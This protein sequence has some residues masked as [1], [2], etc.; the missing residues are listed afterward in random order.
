MSLQW[1]L[2]KLSKV[3]QSHRVAAS[4]AASVSLS[5]TGRERCWFFLI[6]TS[7]MRT[8]KV[9]F[10]HSTFYTWN[11]SQA[12]R[13]LW[14]ELLVTFYP[15]VKKAFLTYV[16]W[17]KSV[18]NSQRHQLFRY[19]CYRFRWLSFILINKDSQT[20]FDIYKKY[21]SKTISKYEKNHL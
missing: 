1:S 9:F 12:L 11:T 8:G 6:K 7:W 2:K 17:N 16:S 15:V 21:L 19:K 14:R 4:I 10:D 20:Y 5:I 18:S 3:D 13:G